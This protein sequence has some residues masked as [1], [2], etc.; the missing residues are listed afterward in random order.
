[1][2]F[3]ICYKGAFN[4]NYIKQR[5]VDNNLLNIVKDTIVNHKTM[6]YSDLIES[7]NDVDTFI[8]SYNLDNRLNEILINGYNAKGYNFFDKNQIST[9]TWMAQ[10]NHLKYLIKLIKTE[11]TNSGFNYD[12]FIFTRF[13]IDFH[14]NYNTFN[15]EL[16]KLNITVEHPSGNCDDNL[17]IFPRNYLDIFENSVDALIFENKITHE[18]NHKI[19]NFGGQINYIDNL[20]DSYMGHTIFSFI[21]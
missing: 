9:S 4:I 6:I 15:L 2:K 21:R 7:G 1:M 12:Y 18:L 11:E 14:K 3:A 13:D 8:S 16:D 5:G 19:I 20:V 10:L 17:W